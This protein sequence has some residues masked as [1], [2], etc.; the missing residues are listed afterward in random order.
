MTLC[1]VVD[2]HD[3]QTLD[4]KAAQTRHEGGVVVVQWIHSPRQLAASC[5]TA[6]V[7]I[8]LPWWLTATW[9]RPCQTILPVYNDLA[10]H[11][12]TTS[13]TTRQKKNHIAFCLVN[14]DD[15]TESIANEFK[16]S[17]MPTLVVLRNGQQVDT[18]SGS[19][20]ARLRQLIERHLEDHNQHYYY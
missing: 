20:A 13:T 9:C 3:E 1:A 19:D 5:A 7:C 16:I 15:E 18:Y 4:N 12:S 6:Y 8:P 14:V 17:M 2:Q 10:A 11:W